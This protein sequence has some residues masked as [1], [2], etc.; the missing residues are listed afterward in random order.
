[1]EPKAGPCPY[2]GCLC[3]QPQEET[4]FSHVCR[5]GFDV[6]CPLNL[7]V[8]SLCVQVSSEAQSLCFSLQS[9]FLA[10]SSRLLG[11]IEEYL[12]P[13]SHGRALSL[14][15]TSEHPSALQHWQGVQENPKGSTE[16]H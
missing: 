9:V 11:R 7:L 8:E 3:P 1:M 12:G 13:L 2:P 4:H 14:S 5:T 6:S 10:S 16:T 15:S